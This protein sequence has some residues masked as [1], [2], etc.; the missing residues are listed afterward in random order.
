MTKK[1]E[2]LFSLLTWGKSA[3][4]THTAGRQCSLTV[5]HSVQCKKEVFEFA[6]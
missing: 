6:F 5:G 2:K 4:Q 1:E 3:R